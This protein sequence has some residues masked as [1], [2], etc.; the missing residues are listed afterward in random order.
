MANFAYDLQAAARN[1]AHA[2][3]VCILARGVDANARGEEGRTAS[4]TPR[5]LDILRSW[6]NSSRMEQTRT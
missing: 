6:P 4:T 3:V 1:G 5:C 2:E